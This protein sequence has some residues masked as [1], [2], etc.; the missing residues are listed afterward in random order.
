MTKE[1]IELLKQQTLF[2]LRGEKNRAIN[3]LFERL[4][5][6]EE[7]EMAVDNLREFP[8]IRAAFL[9]EVAETILGA[10]EVDSGKGKI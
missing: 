5:R 9:Q 4:C 6:D 10:L 7:G 3:T 1:Q 8:D 2:L